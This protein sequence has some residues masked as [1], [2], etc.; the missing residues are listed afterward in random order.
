MELDKPLSLDCAMGPLS[1]TH[2]VAMHR[3]EQ[4]KVGI[5]CHPLLDRCSSSSES[6]PFT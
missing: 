2:P 5:H 3:T 6:C 4:R 1:P